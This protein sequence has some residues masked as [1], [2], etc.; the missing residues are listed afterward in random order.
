MRIIQAICEVV[1]QGRC[2][3]FLPKSC[4]L[5]V[6]KD[7]D[8]VLIHANTGTKPINYMPKVQ[9]ISYATER[10]EDGTTELPTLLVSNAHE[11]LRI[12]LYQIV[13]DNTYDF[14][15]D[16]G[17][18][19]ALEKHQSED[20]LQGW[21]V[22]HF[23]EEFDEHGVQFVCREFE[24]GKGPVDLLGFSPA[25][26]QI[27]LIEVKRHAKLKDAY[28]V[29]RYKHAADEIYATLA[30]QGID[31]FQAYSSKR[32]AS[33]GIVD[34]E[35]SITLPAESLRHPMMFLLA[36][37]FTSGASEECEKN[38]IIT[39]KTHAFSKE[40]PSKEKRNKKS[41]KEETDE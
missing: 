11:I 16:E 7:D 2:K 30:A 40:K 32:T 5:I 29:L 34:I 13:A 35:H 4:R 23:H 19:S 37:T 8:T 20:E 25:Q 38:G 39:I 36:E 27:A 18:I 12:R 21:I 17:N 26:Q 15:E 1:Y 10:S 22:Q 3:T 6:I 41:S 24:T 31:A 14:P 28:Q 33:I 9:A